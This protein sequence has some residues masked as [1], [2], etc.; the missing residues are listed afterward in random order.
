MRILRRISLLAAAAAILVL[1]GCPS[2]SGHGGA[3][4]PVD[5]TVPGDVPEEDG[6]GPELCHD[7][8]D[9]PGRFCDPISGV[10]VDCVNNAHCGEG[11]ICDKWVC[12]PVQECEEDADCS[13][14][15]VCDPVAG[16]C[17][18]CL[19]DEHCPAD[20]VCVNQTC[21]VSCLDGSPCPA[22]TVCDPDTNAC[23]ECLS[24]EDCGEPQWCNV[25]QMLCYPDV[26]DPGEFVCDGNAVVE[27][28]DNGSGWG[29][30]MPCPPDTICIGGECQEG[31]ICVPGLITCKDENTLSECNDDGTVITEIPC[32][33]DTTCKDGVCT[34][35]CVPD[36]AGKECGASGCPGYSCGSCPDGEHCQDFQCVAGE[37][38]EGEVT[39]QWGML[40]E[41]GVGPDGLGYWMEP[42]PCPPGFTCEDGECVPVEDCG[43]IS[44][45]G[46]CQDNTLMY[47]EDGQL[48]IEECGADGLCGWDPQAQFYS[49]GTN[50]QADPSG[51]YPKDCGPC[52]P[53]CAGKECGSDGC[54]GSC[55]VCGLN[56]Q[57]TPGGKC[58]GPDCLPGETLCDGDVLLVCGMGGK[59]HPEPCPPGTTCEDGQC[60]TVCTP[61][62]A[63]KDCGPDGCGDSCGTCPTGASCN[64]GGICVP[65]CVPECP[66]NV[67][68]GSDGCGGI[69]GVCDSDEACVDGI[70]QQSLTC[71]ELQQCYWQCSW[72]EEC[73]QQCWA[74]ASIDAQFQWMAIMQ[75]ISA[76]CGQPPGEQCWQSAIGQGGECQDEWNTC[77][78]CTP[79]CEGLQCGS[80]GCGGIC[81]TCP[82]G[83]ECDVHG[84][85]LCAPQCDGKACG[86]DGCGGQCGFCGAGD[87][88]NYLG[89]CVCMPQCEGKE[90]GSDG[91]GGSCGYCPPG[92]FC[93]DAGLCDEP[94]CPAGE[95]LDCDG[96]CAPAEW[97]GDG[98][99]DGPG[100]EFGA[101][102][103]CPEF[104]WDEGDC[105]QE[106]CG[107]QYCQE[108]LGEDCETCPQDCGPCPGECQDGFVKDC[109]DKCRPEWLLG[110]GQCN[111][112]TGG[113]PGNPGGGANF[114]CPEWEFDFG[115]CQEE[116]WFC[117]D[118]WCDY[119]FGESC[120]NCPEDCGSCGGGDCC[121]PHDGPGCDDP[122]VTGCVCQFDQFC[123][124]QYWDAIC[125]D[126]AQ[127]QCG[128]WCGGPTECEEI[129]AE[130][131][132][133]EWENC[134]CGTCPDGLE[135][136]NGQCMPNDPMCEMLCQM[137]ECGEV[138]PCD[139]GG[140]PWGEECVQ[141]QCMGSD[142]CEEICW[143]KQC[144][145]FQGCYCGS[146]PPNSIC[147][148]DG[149]CIVEGEG[150]SCQE[151]V[152]CAFDCGFT[153]TCIF[154]CYSEGSEL[155]QSQF[156]DLSLCVIQVCGAPDVDCFQEAVSGPCAQQFQ[157]CM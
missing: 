68:C 38:A 55:G 148:D 56:E 81:G 65:T 126:E 77:Q 41:C 102:F 96:K 80:D 22:G 8:G 136:Q 1:T 156:Q 127:D 24:D 7:D 20:Q 61:S 155:G 6:S 30:P 43:D 73:N 71:V 95:I 17:V 97:V 16:I 130:F 85:C 146:C 72:S 141:N 150:L 103:Y 28:L 101:N 120:V 3:V 94:Q 109:D 62:C 33:G 121:E 60:T 78:E 100:S 5:D 147:T 149:Q 138:G 10:C 82:A 75:C 122:E 145:F 40:V 47:C 99:C 114:N 142:P 11:M 45:I 137:V 58:L 44:W 108:E 111:D 139:C 124:E 70:C 34:E 31:K 25:A 13:D 51:T 12:I 39:C 21:L 125:V 89:Q 106:Q 74:D 69:C 112:G 119:D 79:E 151:L 152:E 93:S 118:G 15:M 66:D 129:C 27:C 132:C 105:D 116:P 57:C 18:G 83:F 9:C 52:I 87:V 35:D 53:D 46:C 113:G 143:D 133:G 4:I 64:Q 135:C 26:C 131:E 153:S 37:C 110:N 90:C 32:P 91:C 76:V 107:N 104:D 54:D 42:T 123:C 63:G 19:T 67:E 86:P 29:D 92:S 48:V 59:W 84:Y 134:Y 128:L 36:C 23:V 50:G 88:C 157:T 144:G 117:G 49:C 140:C 2:G 98:Y 115:D 14:G 154:E